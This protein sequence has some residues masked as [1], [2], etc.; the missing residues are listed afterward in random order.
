MSDA[1]TPLTSATA[2]VLE[3]AWADIR[4]RTPD[5]LGDPVF[6]IKSDKRA[7]GHMTV[8]RTWAE[9]LPDGTQGPVRRFHEIMLSAELMAQSTAR[10]LQT[11]IHEAAHTVAAERGVKDTS[12]QYRYHNGRFREIAEE[13]GLFWSHVRPETTKIDGQECLL[14]DDETGSHTDEDG[15]LL[16]PVEARADDTHGYSDMHVSADTLSAYADTLADL[17]TIRIKH[18]A[19]R[20]GYRAPKRRRTVCLVTADV[21]PAER[22]EDRDAAEEACGAVFRDDEIQRIGATVYAGLAER[23]LLAPHLH[24]FENV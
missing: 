21:S 6:V 3:S 13:M 11:M 9:R 23:G 5:V 20:A 2:A 15:F 1:P 8:H 18:T 14:V 10:I 17:E 16:F 19:P 7:W 4:S 12:R 22:Y 24:W